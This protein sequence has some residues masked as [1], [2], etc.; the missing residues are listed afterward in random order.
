MA[1]A[2]RFANDDGDDAR[3]DGEQKQDPGAQAGDAVF[4]L[5]QSNSRL[6]APLPLEVSLGSR[7]PVGRVTGLVLFTGGP[8]SMRFSTC[9]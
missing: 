4:F 7:R 6:D 3:R 2:D 8:R 1:R 5:Q 9:S